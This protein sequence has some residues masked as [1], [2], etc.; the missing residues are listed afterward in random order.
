MFRHRAPQPTNVFNDHLNCP[1]VLSGC[2]SCSG[3]LF[4]S[5]GPAVAKQR[6]PNWLRDLLTRHVRLSADH[7]GRW[8][9]AETSVHSSARYTGAVPANEWQTRVDIL[10]YTRLRTGSQCS[11]C[12]AG[13]W[14]ACTAWLRHIMVMHL[15]MVIYM[16]HLQSPST[17]CASCRTHKVDWVRLN[18]L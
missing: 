7:R 11:W 5:V 6:S 12:R 9:S 8:P 14:C 15:M 17:R 3:R 13:V 16:A 2:R 18:T 1:K 4:H 10:K